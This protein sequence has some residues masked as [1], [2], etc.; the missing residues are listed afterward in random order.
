V[1]AD[2]S[3]AEFCGLAA[4]VGVTCDTLRYPS[5]VMPYFSDASA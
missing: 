1:R 3:E 2:I 4:A 5:Q